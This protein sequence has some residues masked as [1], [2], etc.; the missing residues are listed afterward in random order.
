M[1]NPPGR[2]PGT[3]AGMKNTPLLPAFVVVALAVCA[4]AC[5][6]GADEPAPR[7]S[8]SVDRTPEGQLTLTETVVIEAPVAE[9]WDAYTTSEG[10][11]SWA[12]PVA[13]A[14]LRAGGTIRASYDP[15]RG[16][17]GD[18]VITL[19]IVNYVPQR[20]LTL[21]TDATENWPEVLK[22][23][24]ENLYN[25]ILFDALEPGRTRVTSYGLGYTDSPE[26]RRMMGFFEQQNRGLYERLIAHLE[27]ER[28]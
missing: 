11:A 28:P 20:L 8:H 9:V 5:F 14:D 26:L 13:E 15:E 24:A 27:G 23:D 19:H 17:E 6:A 4:F 2:A 7:I 21:R 1:F 25:V 18:H 16:L 12:A 3:L 10:Y 22:K